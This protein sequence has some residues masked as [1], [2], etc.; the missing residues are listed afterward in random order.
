MLL[1]EQLEKDLTSALKAG[2]KKTLSVIRMLKTAIQNAKANQRDVPTD[3]EFINI[4]RK[5][6]KVRES[7]LEEY[8]KYNR[9]DFVETLEEEIKVLKTY[10]PVEMTEEEVNA[11]IEEIFKAEKPTTIKDMGKV[12][13]LITE[14]VAGRYD[15][16]KISLIV[17]SKLS[18]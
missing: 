3:E 5:Q 7:S 16:G 14:K 12:M 6:I 17:K 4:L 18:N 10:L 11:I 13:K 2:D 1:I 8:K 15:T 9:L